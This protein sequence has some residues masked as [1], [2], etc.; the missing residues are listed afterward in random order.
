MLQVTLDSQGSVLRSPSSADP[1]NNTLYL[2]LKNTGATSLAAGG[3]QF[4]NPRV[5]VSFVYGNTSGALA[6]TTYD[7]A[8]G[9]Q[10]GSAW[11]IAVRHLIGP[12]AVDRRRSAL[13]EA[14]ITPR[15][16]R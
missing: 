10:F 4:G 15:S 5:L 7:P 16:G 8:I 1:L 13:R 12:D 3:Q 6:P 14:R 9:A 11:K 2:T